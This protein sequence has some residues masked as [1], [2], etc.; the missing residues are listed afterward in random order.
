MLIVS[1]ITSAKE[2]IRAITYPSGMVFVNVSLAITV[3]GV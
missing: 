1:D 2:N 3:S